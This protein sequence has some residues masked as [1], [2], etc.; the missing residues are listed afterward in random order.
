ML[1]ACVSVFMLTLLVLCSFRKSSM[2]DSLVA[3]SVAVA[4]SRAWVWYL[5][6]GAHAQDH[7]CD[8]L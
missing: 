3:V 7:S 1:I 2:P 6:H 8:I 4:G 5:G